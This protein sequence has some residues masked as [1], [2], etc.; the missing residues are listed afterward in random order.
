MNVTTGNLLENGSFDGGAHYEQD[1]DGNEIPQ[2]Q[3]GDGWMP[4]W[5]ETDTR[6]EYVVDPRDAERRVRSG[7]NCQHWFNTFATHTAGVFQRVNGS[8]TWGHGDTLVATAFVQAWSSGEDDPSESDGRYRMRIGIDPYGGLDPESTDI[9]WSETVQPYDEYFGINVTTKALS[10]RATVFLWGQSEWPM[11]HNDAYTDDIQLVAIVSDGQPGDP[12]D[13]DPPIDP[14]TIDITKFVELVAAAT[15]KRIFL[16]VANICTVVA[17]M[18][19]S[20]YEKG[21]PE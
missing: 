21:D 13:G 4:W 9:A 18:I 12:P 8:G 19:R 16:T 1:K 10:D 3:V 2:V 15:E 6:P 17:S 7:V 20:A 14:P 5:H 11:K